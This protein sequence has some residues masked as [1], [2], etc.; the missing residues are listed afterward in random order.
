MIINNLLKDKIKYMIINNL[1]KDKIKYI[2][3]YNNY[4]KNIY[5]NLKN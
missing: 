1:L 5:N 4:N 2:I 3:K